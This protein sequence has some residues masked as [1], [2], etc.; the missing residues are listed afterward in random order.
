MV[1]A[2]QASHA[3]DYANSLGL[4][5]RGPGSHHY[6]VDPLLPLTARPKG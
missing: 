6:S 3:E 1:L 4:V 5:H 2:G